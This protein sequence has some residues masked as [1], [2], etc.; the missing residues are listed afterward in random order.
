MYVPGEEPFN[1]TGEGKNGVKADF[2]PINRYV[3]DMIEDRHTIT[4]DD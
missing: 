4:T 3:S 1:E 2:R